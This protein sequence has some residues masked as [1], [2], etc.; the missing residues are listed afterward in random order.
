MKSF[1]VLFLYFG[2]ADCVEEQLNDEIMVRV[3][4]FGFCVLHFRD[5]NHLHILNVDSF[6]N[7]VEFK[8]LLN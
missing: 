6:Y 2:V 4:N 7:C 5:I 1:L 3:L 8:K